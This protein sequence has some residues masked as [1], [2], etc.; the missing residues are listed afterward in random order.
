[1][2][3]IC[4]QSPRKSVNCKRRG[5]IRSGYGAACVASARGDS[6][7]LSILSY[8][9]CASARERWLSLNKWK[10]GNTMPVRDK[11]KD[12]LEDFFDD[13]K[14]WAVY[15]DKCRAANAAVSL[16]HARLYAAIPPNARVLDVGCGPGLSSKVLPNVEYFGFD[17]STPALRVAKSDAG[18]H[19]VGF[20]RGNAMELPYASERFDVVLSLRLVEYILRPQ[21]YLREMVRV[22]RPGGAAAVERSCVGT[23][24]PAACE[25]AKR[26]RPAAQAVRDRP[27]GATTR[28]SGHEEQDVL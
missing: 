19:C 12:R 11:L 14:T 6:F 2:L 8:S 15:L 16:D 3:I 5:I 13:P 21:D 9:V 17:F 20:V 28:V 18:T 7:R 10:V 4:Y 22:L 27:A 26:H 23:A 25:Y 24:V 1:M